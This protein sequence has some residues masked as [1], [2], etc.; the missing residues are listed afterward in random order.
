MEFLREEQIFSKYGDKVITEYSLKNGVAEIS[1]DTQMTLFTANGL[2]LGT[3]RGMTR[4]I[5]GSYESYIQ[6]M[7]K[8][9]YRTQTEP[10]PINEDYLYS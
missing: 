7:Y 10:Y 1:D 6:T 4:G 3:P 5:M 9:C 8:C 2:L